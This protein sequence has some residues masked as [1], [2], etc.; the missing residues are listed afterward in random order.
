MKPK[1]QKIKRIQ[2]H[3]SDIKHKCNL[4]IEELEQLTNYN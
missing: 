4:V 3:L 2:R 1:E